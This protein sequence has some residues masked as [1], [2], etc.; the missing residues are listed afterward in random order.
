MQ[1]SGESDPLFPYLLMQHP[2]A[3]VDSIP[4]PVSQVR[5]YAESYSVNRAS[6]GLPC[7]L[8]LHYFKFTCAHFTRKKW[9]FYLPALKTLPRVWR[10]KSI[11]VTRGRGFDSHSLIH[12]GLV[13]LAKESPSIREHKGLGIMARVLLHFGDPGF[14]E[15][16]L[17]PWYLG[18]S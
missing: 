13:I 2:L 7:S 3:H 8:S 10:A 12:I 6:W 18:S 1:G 14:L 15:F 5:F 9:F 17:M 11:F 16:S 4:K